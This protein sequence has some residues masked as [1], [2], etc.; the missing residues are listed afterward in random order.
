LTGNGTFEPAV[1][2]FPVVAT[3]NAVRGYR[4]VGFFNHTSRDVDLSIEGRSV[5]L[6][7]KTYLEAKLA[8]TF[9]W[10]YGDRPTVR[11]HVPDG[12]QGLDVVFRE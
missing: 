7:A 4:T 8:Q 9:T 1:N 11:E 12:A 2:V 5:K 6:P 10:G 3:E